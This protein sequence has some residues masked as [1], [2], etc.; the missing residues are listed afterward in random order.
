[1]YIHKYTHD[2]TIFH[3]HTR[4]GSHLLMTS[5]GKK[6]LG[7][8]WNHLYW[9]CGYFSPLPLSS[10]QQQDP[11]RELFFDL[12]VVKLTFGDAHPPQT[13]YSPTG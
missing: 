13:I 5:S 1:M 9:Y 6:T 11:K 8:T 10:L 2:F 12:Q 3:T 7:T 4:I